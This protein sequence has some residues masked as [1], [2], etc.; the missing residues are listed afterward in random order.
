MQSAVT[1]PSSRFRYIKFSIHT[2]IDNK[3]CY[4]LKSFKKLNLKIVCIYTEERRNINLHL[5]I[6][7][8][9]RCQID[10]CD[11]TYRSEV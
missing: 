3:D 5:H 10:G 9:L 11:R 2:F 6:I 8:D 1:E 7:L 4:S